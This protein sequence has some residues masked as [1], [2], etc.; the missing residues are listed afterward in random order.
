MTSAEL[1]AKAI[2]RMGPRRVACAVEVALLR[3]ET[4][5]AALAPRAGEPWDR[6]RSRELDVAEEVVTRLRELAAVLGVA[7]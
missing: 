6:D 1:V 2:M 3:A 5:R 4:W 7:Q